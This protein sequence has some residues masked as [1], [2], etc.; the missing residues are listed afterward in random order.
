MKT[1][2]IITIVFLPLFSFLFFA[3]QGYSNSET[4]KKPVHQKLEPEKTDLSQLDILQNY[5]RDIWTG[6]EGWNDEPRFRS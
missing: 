6:P 5:D 4:S 1:Q 2:S 3:C